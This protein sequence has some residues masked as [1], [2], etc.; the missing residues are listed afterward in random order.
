MTGLLRESGPGL[1]VVFANLLT[2]SDILRARKDGL[3]YTLVAYPLFSAAG[4]GLLAERPRSGAP[5]AGAQPVQPAAVHQGLRADAAAQRHRHGERGPSRRP[6]RRT[7]RSRPGSPINVR[8]SANA[9]YGGKPVAQDQPNS[10]RRPGRRRRP[11]W[12]RTACPARSASRAPA[13]RAWPPCSDCRAEQREVSGEHVKSEVEDVE[14]TET[15]EAD[16]IRRAGRAGGP[17]R[18]ATS[19][20]CSAAGCRSCCSRSRSRWSWRPPRSPCGSA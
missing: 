3:E 14:T 15:T 18:T 19:R 4:K 8:G 13:N 12:P 16:G 20:A 10:G 6:R 1:G 2:T 17:P 11:G 7:V 5:R 9:P